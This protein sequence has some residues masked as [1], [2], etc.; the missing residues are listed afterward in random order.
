MDLSG[1]DAISTTEPS[2]ADAHCEAL[3]MLNGTIINSPTSSTSSAAFTTNEIPRP[4]AYTRASID[5]ASGHGRSMSAADTARKSKRF[6]MTFP[7]NTTATHASRTSSPVRPSPPLTLP[8]SVAAPTASTGPTGPTDSS[9]LTA[10]AT[11]ERRV[12]EL[13][14]ELHKAE[15]E[16]KRLKQEWALHE[17]QRKRHDARRLQ[18]LQPLHMASVPFRKPLEDDPDGSSAWMQQEMERRK[19]LLNG[20]KPSNR[21][22]FSGSRHARTLSL[23]SPTAASSSGKAATPRDTRIRSRSPTV[24]ERPSHVVRLPTDEILS[25]EVAQTADSNIDLGLPRDVLMKTGKQMANDFRDG[26]WTFIEDLRQATVGEEG[27]NGTTTRTQ[28]QSHP[29]AEQRS[30]RQQPSR[31][32]LKAPVRPQSLKRSSTTGS[33]RTRGPSAVKRADGPDNAALLDLGGSFWQ[34]NGFDAAKIPERPLTK[35]VSKRKLDSPRKSQHATKDSFDGWDNWDSPERES[36]TITC[37]SDTSTS[38]VRTSPSPDGTSPR[39]SSRSVLE[40]GA[41]T[42]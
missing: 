24:P 23:L 36:K 22:V 10:I 30:L 15:G 20:A 33:S 2:V 3:S 18:K 1:L 35:K 21:T 38:D 5:V 8:E 37:N 16:L 6:T 26:L 32:S 34:E 7:I 25:T 41:R 39:T 40:V 19:A 13:K 17:A 9:F 14:E 4:P 29:H 28:S 12:L 42:I 31:G 11:Q 27:V